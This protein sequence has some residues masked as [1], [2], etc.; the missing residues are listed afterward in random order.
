[1]TS[2]ERAESAYHQSVFAGDHSRVAS[3]LVDLHGDSPAVELARGKLMHCANLQSRREDRSELECFQRA[4]AAYEERGDNRGLAEAL[5]WEGCYHQVLGRDDHAAVA[6]LEHALV[7]ARD[8]D[9]PLIQSYCLRH[10]GI[11]SHAEG[12]LIA[13]ERR[14]TESTDLRR[15]RGFS[16]GVAA[17]LVGLAFVAVA[18]GNRIQAENRAEQ[19]LQMAHDCNANAVANDAR[20]ALSAAQELA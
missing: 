14:L 12:D 2:L 6:I 8:A 5:F 10:L 7:L 1:M 16:A 13:A 15:Q 11:A 19:A 3:C 18:R 9:D 20:S 4:A 17:N